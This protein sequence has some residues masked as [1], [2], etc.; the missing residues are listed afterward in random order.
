[1]ELARSL[2]KPAPIW[3]GTVMLWL[4]WADTQNPRAP[5]FILD[6]PAEEKEWRD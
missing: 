5:P 3:M 2:P 6:D 4:E 1:M